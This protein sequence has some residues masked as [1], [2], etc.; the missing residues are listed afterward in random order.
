MFKKHGKMK[1]TC[2]AKEKS[3]TVTS[4]CDLDEACHSGLYLLLVHIAQGVA[5][6]QQAHAGTQF[7]HCFPSFGSINGNEHLHEFYAPPGVAF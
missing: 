1:V 7:R 3:L 4:A 6:P 5:L 2:E